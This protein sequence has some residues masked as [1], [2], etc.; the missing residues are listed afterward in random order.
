[1]LGF[2]RKKP[3]HQLAANAKWAQHMNSKQK[4]G[5]LTMISYSL[6]QKISLN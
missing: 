1:M 6:K 2:A 4:S 3:Y 5:K